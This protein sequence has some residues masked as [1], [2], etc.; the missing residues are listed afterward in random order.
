ME[1]ILA[2][3]V[4]VLAIGSIALLFF[5]VYHFCVWLEE[6]GRMKERDSTE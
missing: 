3:L 4:F 1:V 2:I 6:R 5:G